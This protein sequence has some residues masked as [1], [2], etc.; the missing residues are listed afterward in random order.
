MG[1]MWHQCEMEEARRPRRGGRELDGSK[2]RRSQFGGSKV[3]WRDLAGSRLG[4]SELDGSW[5]EYG[6]SPSASAQS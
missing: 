4:W 2:L 1:A 3:R 5:L 6:G